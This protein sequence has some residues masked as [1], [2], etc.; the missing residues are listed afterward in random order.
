MVDEGRCKAEKRGVRDH[1]NKKGAPKEVRRAREG[2][3]GRG[4]HW[5]IVETASRGRTIASAMQ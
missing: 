3:T 4:T 5:G 1:G 2:E